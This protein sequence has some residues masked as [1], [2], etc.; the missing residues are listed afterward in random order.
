MSGSPARKIITFSALIAIIAVL[1]PFSVSCSKPPR[2][3]ADFSVSWVSGERLLEDPITGTAPLT[4]KFTDQSSGEITSWRWN[5]GDGPSIEGSGEEYQNPAHTYTTTNSSGF[6][7]V[8]TVKG[9]GGKS[10]PTDKT[11]VT[12]LSCSEAANSELNQAR[13][14]VEDCVKAAGRNTLDSEVLGWDGSSGKVVVSGED[15]AQYLGV[16]NHFKATYNVGQD[17]TIMSGT[18][19]SW[20]CIWW[21]SS[22]APQAR[23][24]AL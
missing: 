7:V 1:V 24:G 8:L 20:G 21:N 18:D 11:A 17:G 22:A 6:I 5:F 12:V 19:T 3:T 13:K 9:P 16:W 2:P 23:W 15:A 10:E 4:V 14:A